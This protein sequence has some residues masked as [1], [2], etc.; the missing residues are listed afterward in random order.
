[1][2][3]NADQLFTEKDVLFGSRVDG[4]Y[5]RASQI[6]HPVSEVEHRCFDKGSNLRVYSDEDDD[7]GKAPVSWLDFCFHTNWFH[8]LIILRSNRRVIHDQRQG[9]ARHP[10]KSEAAITLIDGLGSM[11]SRKKSCRTI[12]RSWI[13]IPGA[14]AQTKLVLCNFYFRFRMFRWR[15]S[16]IMA[17]LD[18]I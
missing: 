8:H 18:V 14:G 5:S 6:V 3:S 1:M 15:L 11:V 2:T 7:S 12:F 17:Y 13:I 16:S 4:C 9:R 10:Q